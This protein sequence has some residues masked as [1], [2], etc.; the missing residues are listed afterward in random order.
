MD[1]ARDAIGVAG[2][3][4][5]R[6]VQCAAWLLV[7]LAAV[8]YILWRFSGPAPLQTNLPRCCRPRRRTRLPNARSTCWAMRSAIAPSTW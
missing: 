4:A 1:P 3:R 7:T 6:C 5:R 8:A 2:E